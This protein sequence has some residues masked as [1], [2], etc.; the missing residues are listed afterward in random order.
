MALNWM[1][2]L[3]DRSEALGGAAVAMTVAVPYC[4]LLYVKPRETQYY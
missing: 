1:A 2:L 4:N 3:N